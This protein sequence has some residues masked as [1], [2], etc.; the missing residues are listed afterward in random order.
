MEKDMKFLLT[1]LDE[2]GFAMRKITVPHYWCGGT[3]GVE[4]EWNEPQNW[5]NRRIPGWFDEVI[6]SGEHTLL[7]YFPII[8]DF[9]TDVAMIKVLPGGQLFISRHGKLSI[10]GLHKKPIGL[11]NY[12]RVQVEGELTIH[13]MNKTNIFNRG[14]IRN[15][16][17]IALDKSEKNG[18]IGTEQ[19]RFDNF[20]ELLF[21]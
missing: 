15:N 18:I 9:V 11:Q 17:S 4:N 8:S 1:S 3:E 7:S 19:S 2:G 12:G 10:D 16:G 13:R 14:F 20:G 5:Y 6:I 21:I